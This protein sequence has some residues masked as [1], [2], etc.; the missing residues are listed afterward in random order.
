MSS[1][2]T[3]LLP[4]ML[5]G[6]E[7]NKVLRQLPQAP[8]DNFRRNATQTERLIML[9][10]LYDIYIPNQMAMDIYSKLYISLMRSLSKKQTKLA[11]IQANQNHFAAR[12][13]IS[14]LGIMG[15]VDVFSVTGVGGI[16]KSSAINRS[17]SVITRDSMIE[18]SDPYT[19]IIPVLTV[20]CPY[21]CSVK[22]L[23]FSILTGVDNILQTNYVQRS[24]RTRATTDMM[25]AQLA[26]CELNDRQMYLV[27][28]Y[29]IYSIYYLSEKMPSVEVAA[30]I[31]QAGQKCIEIA[32][33][34]GDE[35]VC[36]EVKTAMDNLFTEINQRGNE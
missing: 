29:Q 6:A 4:P 1:R 24:I 19:R 32:S 21:D 22:G 20:Q 12:S 26:N 28:F 9:S 10:D 5:T 25:I 17:I 33:R 11:T 15:G 31:G 18:T 35:S 23:I 30:W 7:L 36:Q 3:E 16:G 34:I 8:D 13:G 27:L 2:I 14:K